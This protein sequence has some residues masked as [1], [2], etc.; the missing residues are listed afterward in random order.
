MPNSQPSKITHQDYFRKYKLCAEQYGEILVNLLFRGTKMPDNHK[1][2]DVSA[3]ID[4]KP[5]RIEVKSKV[6]KGATVVHCGANKFGRGRMTHLVVVLV[7]NDKN[8][9]VTE[10]WLLSRKHALKLRRMETQS[11]YINVPHLRREAAKNNGAIK[12]IAKQLQ[13]AAECYA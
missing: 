4:G 3:Q 12:S 1:G 7:D 10:A 13:E 5:A 2:Y 6:A 9:S 11:K 8:F